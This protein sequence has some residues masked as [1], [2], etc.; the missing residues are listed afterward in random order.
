MIVTGKPL[1]TNSFKNSALLNLLGTNNDWRLEWNADVVHFF[2]FFCIVDAIR[3]VAA[4]IRLLCLLLWYGLLKTQVYAVWTDSVS[5]C[6]AGRRQN[7]Y[8]KGVALCREP[9]HSRAVLE[10]V[11][12]VALDLLT[13]TIFLI[14]RLGPSLLRL[15][16]ETSCLIWSV[17]RL[18]KVG[19]SSS[20]LSRPRA[21]PMRRC[22]L[23]RTSISTE[24]W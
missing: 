6:A 3:S 4:C 12:I 17:A 11:A 10:F 15:H 8:A 21:P 24:F 5:R 16:I 23:N 22:R 19:A 14:L 13:L 18:S 7:P 9:R 20:K 2:E 1:S